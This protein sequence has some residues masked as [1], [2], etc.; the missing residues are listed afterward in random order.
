M[1]LT[2]G[3]GILALMSKPTLLPKLVLCELSDPGVPGVESYSPFC[4]KIHRALRAAGLPYERRFAARPD[5]HAKHNPARQ[6]P[7]LLVDGEPVSDSTAIL[8]R[9]ESLAGPFAPHLDASARAEAWLWEEF[10]DTS[11]NALLV[12]ARWADDRNWPLVREAYFGSAP[13]IVRALVAPRLRAKVIGTLVARDV[14]RRG[15]DACWARLEAV[16]DQLEWRAPVRGFWLGDALSVADIAIFAQLQ[17]LRTALTAPQRD[18]LALR[19]ELSAYLDR[20]DRATSRRYMLPAVVQSV[21]A[22]QPAA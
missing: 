19:A 1:R 17:S 12:A 20:V 9:I 18:A 14:W 8:A 13:W 5:A 4:L 21:I 10:A 11:L 3:H 2:L 16:L 6:V 22:A 15:A 7:V